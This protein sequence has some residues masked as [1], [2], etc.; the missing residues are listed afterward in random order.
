MFQVVE[1]QTSFVEEID[2]QVFGNFCYS[3]ILLVKERHHQFQDLNKVCVNFHN[4]F[5]R[6]MR[7]VWSN[8]QLGVKPKFKVTMSL[9]RVYFYC[10]TVPWATYIGNKA[11]SFH[12]KNFRFILGKTS[13]GRLTNNKDIFMHWL[14]YLSSR[15]KFVQLWLASHVSQISAGRIPHRLFYSI[16]K[17]R[18]RRIGHLARSERLCNWAQDLVFY[19]YIQAVKLMLG[20]L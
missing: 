5:S 1:T 18:T 14:C 2:F 9:F 7:L 6:L 17:K 20:Y 4:F 3:E 8:R 10:S 19:L 12:T 11:W 13:V 15:W 16:L